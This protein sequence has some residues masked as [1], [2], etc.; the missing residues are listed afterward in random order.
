MKSLSL[1]QPHVI[2]MVGVPGSG[3]SFFAD[4]FADTFHAPLVSF[5]KIASIAGLEPADELMG[6]QLD[7]LFKT[8]QSIIIDGAADSKTERLELARKARSCGYEPLL[9]WVQIDPAAAEQRSTRRTKDQPTP[10]LTVEEYEWRLK[11][12]T[13]PS[14]IE[15]PIVISG[16]HTYATQVKVVLKKLSAPRARISTHAVAPTRTTS[17]AP[18]TRRNITV[19]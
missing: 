7:E 5:D 12:F 10:R 1:S 11:R 3:K 19:R 4:K 9:V 2:I 16:K 6:Y 14:A 18:T 8:N 17:D 13:A 15:K